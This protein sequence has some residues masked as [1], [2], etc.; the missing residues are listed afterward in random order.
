M[1]FGGNDYKRLRELKQSTDSAVETTMGLAKKFRRAYQLRMNQVQK[2]KPYLNNSPYPEIFCGDFN[3]VSSSRIYVDLKGDRQDAF[4]K[5]GFGI[6]RTFAYMSPT[7]RID[8]ILVNKQFKVLQTKRDKI[9]LSDH[10][11]VITDLELPAT[12]QE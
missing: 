8:Y 7:L 3:E 1:L 10:Y 2:L 6:G 12:E 11:P 5:K 4:I 9:L